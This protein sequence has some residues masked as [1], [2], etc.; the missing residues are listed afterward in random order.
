MD[1]AF[2][3]DALFYQMVEHGIPADASVTLQRGIRILLDKEQLLARLLVSLPTPL[4]PYKPSR[5][6]FN[7]LIHDFWYHA[8]WTAKKLR[9][10]ELWT[11]MG[12]SNAYMK[13]RLSRMLE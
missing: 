5:Q 10:R 1:F 9:R 7:E 4:P 3:P 2:Y 6:E 13:W 8:I 11:A 12:C